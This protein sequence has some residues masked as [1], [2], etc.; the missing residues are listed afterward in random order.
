VS[1]KT[2]RVVAVLAVVVILG[3]AATGTGTYVSQGGSEK[4]SATVK[5][6]VDGDTLDLVGG[7]TVRLVQIDTPEVKDGECYAEDAKRELIRLAPKG[8]RVDLED[9]PR[10][11]A[12]DRYGRLLRYVHA[13]R[14]NLNVELVRLGAA[15]PYFHSGIRGAYADELMDAVNEAQDA[16]RGMWGE[17]RVSWSPNGPVDTRSR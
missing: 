8:T 12:E 7:D 9:D 6:V 16:G 1:R 4:G 15:A 17:C 11:D 5:W 14:T 3:I 13:S 2:K 10:L